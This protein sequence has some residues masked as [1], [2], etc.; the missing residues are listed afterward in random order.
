MGWCLIQNV[1]MSNWLLFVMCPESQN[2]CP[3]NAAVTSWSFSLCL[4]DVVDI[5]FVCK[6]EKV[7]TLL[8]NALNNK[9]KQTGKQTDRYWHTHT[10]TH[11]HTHMHHPLKSMTSKTINSGI[12]II[13]IKYTW[14]YWSIFLSTCSEHILWNVISNLDVCM[15]FCWKGGSPKGS[16]CVRRFRNKKKCLI[17]ESLQHIIST[18]IDVVVYIYFHLFTM[19]RVLCTF[20][21]ILCFFSFL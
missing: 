1:E 5:V 8:P 7:E 4:I 6:K 9:S 11:I 14:L 10:Q 2:L 20:L 16:A 21:L 18:Q 15:W 17:T 12:S 19:K 13:K 3:S